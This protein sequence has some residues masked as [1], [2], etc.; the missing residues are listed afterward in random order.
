MLPQGG[1]KV[2]CNGGAEVE[3]VEEAAAAGVRP[4]AW[5]AVVGVGALVLGGLMWRT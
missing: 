1:Y 5:K 4:R 2:E 3:A